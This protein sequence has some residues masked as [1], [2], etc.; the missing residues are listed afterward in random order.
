MA[1]FYT[2]KEIEEGYRELGIGQGDVVY[3]TGNLGAL[4][5]HESKSK[6]GTIDAHLEA[7]KVVVGAQGT[8]VVP[9][10]SFYLCNTSEVFDV[11]KSRGERGAFTEH[12]RQQ[13]R[14]VR[15]F[16]PFASLTALGLRAAEICERTT[17][18]AYGPNTPYA[19]LLE[20]NA[21]GVSLGLPPQ[22]TC[23]VIHHIEQVM[24]VPYRYTKEFMHPVMRGG[25][26]VV[27][28]F[29]LF[30]TYRDC[31]LVRDRNEKLFADE[32]MQTAC[33]RVGLGFGEM[34]GYRLQALEQVAMRLMSG[35]IYHWLQRAPEVRPYRQ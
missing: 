29:Y 21:W 15:Q 32:G 10:H 19:R 35:D 7:L 9:T 25:E 23:S 30:V 24:A 5:F 18:H 22:R 11:V 14:A 31:D 6:Q 3:V 17:R 2:T 20:M 8:I 4:G 16:H 13:Q 33:R 27:E 34:S 28:P 1:G 12:V 26:V